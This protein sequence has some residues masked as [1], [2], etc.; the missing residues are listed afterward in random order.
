MGKTFVVRPATWSLH[1]RLRGSS[2]LLRRQRDLRRI[3][4][5]PAA[6]WNAKAF[7]LLQKELS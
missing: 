4:T 5:T 7:S 1:H 6:L 2:A 3:G